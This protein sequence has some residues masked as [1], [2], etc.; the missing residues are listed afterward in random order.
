MLPRN[1]KENGSTRQDDILILQF[2]WKEM[3]VALKR[4]DEQMQHSI[5]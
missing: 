2:K 5:M 1:A 3:L 4:N